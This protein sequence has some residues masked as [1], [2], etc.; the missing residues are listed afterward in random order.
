MP[1]SRFLLI[2]ALFYSAIGPLSAQQ[3]PILFTVNGV[4]VRVNEFKY[5]YEKSNNNNTA[6]YSRKSL[7][8]SLELYSKFKISIFKLMIRKSVIISSLKNELNGYKKQLAESYLIDKEITEKLARQY[9]DRSLKDIRISHIFIN[10]GPET[11]PTD[12]LK[13]YEKVKEIAAKLKVGEK[14]EDLEPFYNEDVL[15]K[16]QHGDLGYVTSMLPD[17]FYQLENLAY[18]LKKGETGGPARSKL[19]WHFV[20]V[21][22]IRPARGQMEISQILIRVPK[23]S[24]NVPYL[25]T[26]D[27]IYQQLKKG[28]DFA[29]LAKSLSDDKGTSMRGGYMGYIGIN[30]YDQNFED[31]VFK[32][33]K[34]GDF[35]R[36]FQTD[37]GYHIVKRISQKQITPFEKD[38]KA[39]MTKIMQNERFNLARNELVEKVKAENKFS[40]NTKNY[41]Q[42]LDSINNPTF[43]DATWNRPAINNKTIF[44]IGDKSYSSNDVSDY[45]KENTRRRVRLN[46][47]MSASVGFEQL[48]NEYI[49]EKALEYEEGHLDEKYP[50]Y[51]ALTREYEEGFL[52]FEVT[53]KEVWNKAALDTTG[54]E[55]FYKKNKD[56]YNWEERANLVSYTINEVSPEA[57]LKV[58]EYVK[59]MNTKDLL[60][61]FNTKDKEIITYTSEV[62]EKPVNGVMKDDMSWKVGSVSYPVRNL[63]QKSG[64]V[65][66][67]VSI[68]APAPKE[69]K[70]AR[71][72]VI[73]DYQ[74]Y[75]EKQWVES[76]KKEYKIVVNE[77][78]F[79]SMVKK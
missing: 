71:G 60:N 49:S 6:D 18:N 64:I 15:S 31:Q 9:Y 10:A 26:A 4:P 24:N 13:A 79:N 48:L 40:I 76:L 38:K 73:S 39:Y 30:Q 8:E 29:E 61:K 25:K 1:L 75:L 50:E 22:D 33:E 21:T 63:D 55:A 43:F 37:L 45:M 77:D 65:K 58:V 14:F 52:F 28:V 51:K 78:V 53:S 17:G 19:G 44:T 46:R 74:D 11:L 27:S 23:G 67:I 20:K 35:T 16:L 54:I 70:D 72:F 34:D 32:I 66:K 36:P 47:S 5:I 3:D 68:T 42:Y 62:I 56:K 59:T 57:F 69:L 41:H 2:A 7:N 12:T